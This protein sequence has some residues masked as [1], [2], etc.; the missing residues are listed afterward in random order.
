MTEERRNEIERSISQAAHKA[1]GFTFGYIGNFESWGDDRKLMIWKDNVR[2]WEA[3]AK[4]INEKDL[5]RAMKILKGIKMIS[6]KLNS[7]HL[8]AMV[9]ALR[10]VKAFQIDRDH[11]QGTVV[12]T[13]PKAG[14]VFRALKMGKQDLWLVRHV[15]NLFN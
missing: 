2:V 8:N 10:Q 5:D 15:D 12:A 14:E 4:G 7:E 6:A 13:H 9:K 11:N 3:E 1:E